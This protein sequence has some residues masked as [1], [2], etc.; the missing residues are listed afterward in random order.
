M[1]SEEQVLKV[2]ALTLSKTGNIENNEITTRQ[3]R[4]LATFFI[5]TSI[6]SLHV[7]VKLHPYGTM[8]E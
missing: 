6:T 5:D 2:A 1:L 7:G 8:E 4:P 3:E